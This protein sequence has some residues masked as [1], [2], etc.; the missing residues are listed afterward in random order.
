MTQRTD[1]TQ[2]RRGLY[3]YKQ[4]LQ[5]KYYFTRIFVGN[6]K[7]ICRSTNETSKIEARK[8]A[9]ELYDSLK[10]KN[11]V[12]VSETNS[13]KFYSNK[14]IE[15]E[16][17]LS[18][19][20]RHKR[21][22]KDTE[23]YITRKDYGLNAIFGDMDISKITTF[24]IRDYLEKLDKK[25]KK[26]LTH[27]TKSKYLNCI[28]KIMR[29]GYEYGKLKSIPLMPKLD[30]KNK[31][32]PRP[33]FNEDEYKK[34]LKV[35]RD[36]IE[37]GAMVKRYNGGGIKLTMEHYYFI[38]FM[39]HTFM[40]PVESE[41]YNVKHKDIKVIKEDPARL[42]IQV[43]GKTGYRPIS[44]LSYAVEFY[45]KVAKLH[46]GYKKDDY[47]FFPYYQNRTTAVRT[48]NRVFNY[49]LKKGNL[50]F[51]HFGTKRTSYS[52][53]HYSL[54]TRLRLSKGKVNIYWLAK[55]AGTSVDQLERFYL[56]NI[57][58]NDEIVKNLQ[59]FG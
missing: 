31:D 47:V 13:F 56:K 43:I 41:I 5:S 48:F 33:S 57:E 30:S 52:L 18:K 22:G 40:R 4:P 7:Y 2:I 17:Q 25:N 46:K 10:E 54:Q 23:K 6:K 28:K 12:G 27:S 14:L 42:E 50:E 16:M 19:T 36:E 32:N 1:R 44:S 26:P 39:V 45:E 3:I 24:D 21:F 53:R 34:L 55:N 29:V 15:S 58:L 38:V 35:T 20:K 51:D 11:K 49:I 59:S 8:R 37:K 9:E